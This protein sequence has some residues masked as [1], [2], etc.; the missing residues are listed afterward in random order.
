M[1]QIRKESFTQRY[2]EQNEIIGGL[3]AVVDK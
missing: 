2:T 1:D 3:G